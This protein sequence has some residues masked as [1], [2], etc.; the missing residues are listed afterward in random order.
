MVVWMI[1][2]GQPHHVPWSVCLILLT[3]VSVT[4]G[5]FTDQF[6]IEPNTHDFICWMQ[7]CCWFESKT[8]PKAM[9]VCILCGPRCGVSMPCC[10]APICPGCLQDWW[11]DTRWEPEAEVACPWCNGDPSLWW[12]DEELGIRA[13]ANLSKQMKPCPPAG[14]PSSSKGW[15]LMLER[16]QRIPLECRVCPPNMNLAEF[17]AT[18]PFGTRKPSKRPAPRSIQHQPKRMARAAPTRPT[19]RSLW[20]PFQLIE[21]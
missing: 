10:G 2:A 16:F 20:Q 4:T 7:G 1:T 14:T 18:N 8:K 5:M 19:H 11:E 3:C 13:T 17:L 9:G 6:Q 15:E 12:L 21:L